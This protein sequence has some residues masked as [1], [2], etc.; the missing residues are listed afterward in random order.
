M[1]VLVSVFQVG[2]RGV[3]ARKKQEGKKELAS[4]VHLSLK[5][6]QNQKGRLLQFMQ[7][8]LLHSEISRQSWAKTPCLPFPSFHCK[9]CKCKCKCRRTAKCGGLGRPHMGN[10]PDTVPRPKP[11]IPRFSKRLTAA[12]HRTVVFVHVNGLGFVSGSRL[13]PPSRLPG[14]SRPL[15][16]KKVD[17]TVSSLRRGA[18][19]TGFPQT[20][21]IPRTHSGS[22]HSLIRCYGLDIAEPEGGRRR[23]SMMLG[24]YTTRLSRMTDRG[25]VSLHVSRL[26]TNADRK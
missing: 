14:L 21:E 11:K 9:P 3:F 23:G 25:Q 10:G 17:A 15:K 12:S 20:Q 16:V 18:G 7:T 24:A 6:Y 2:L 19:M 13:G 5:T 4:S 26:S 1:H 8:R 22:N